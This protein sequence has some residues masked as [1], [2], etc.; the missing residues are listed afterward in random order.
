MSYP[1]PWPLYIFL[2]R[3]QDL[4]RARSSAALN[5]RRVEHVFSANGPRGHGERLSER[6]F[7]PTGIIFLRGRRARVSLLLMGTFCGVQSAGNARKVPAFKVPLSKVPI[8]L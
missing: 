1:V 2:D 7:V 5:L 4:E 8:Y 6:G 3:G